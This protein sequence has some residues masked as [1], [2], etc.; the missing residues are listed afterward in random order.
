MK[1]ILQEESYRALYSKYQSYFET[2]QSA[3]FELFFFTII[4]TAIYLASFALIHFQYK[5]ELESERKE[6]KK[7]L[8]IGMTEK[9]WKYMECKK[10]KQDFIVPAI[11]GIIEG[12]LILVQIKSAKWYVCFYEKLVCFTYE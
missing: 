11:P 5:V 4:S 8:D 6:Y 12:M 9:Q 3:W 2:V 1:K 7:L 10:I